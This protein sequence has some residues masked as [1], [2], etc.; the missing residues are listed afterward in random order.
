LSYF[1]ENYFFLRVNSSN[2]E[3]WVTVIQ[4]VIESTMQEAAAKANSAGI[5]FT[6]MFMSSFY[7]HRSQN[8]KNS[9]TASVSFCA[10]GICAR[11]SWS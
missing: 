9:V 4:S 8:R 6:N 2:A 11:K 1:I 3:R 5:Y 10:F 7:A